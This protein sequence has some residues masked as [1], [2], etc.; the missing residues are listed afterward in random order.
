MHIDD[1]AIY[2]QTSLLMVKY[3]TMLDM[4]ASTQSHFTPGSSSITTSNRL[5][6][7]EAGSFYTRKEMPKG[8]K[9]KRRRIK[10]M[11]ITG[12]TQSLE[13][14]NGVAAYGGGKAKGNNSPSC[15]NCGGKTGHYAIYCRLLPR[16]ER[17]FQVVGKKRKTIATSRVSVT[18]NSGTIVTVLRSSM[19]TIGRTDTR[20]TLA[21]CS[22]YTANAGAAPLAMA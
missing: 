3:C 6:P 10:N 11:E 12:K 1:M 9:G 19:A 2:Q 22:S 7:M 21:S 8:R 13:H 15:Y 4:S 16:F 5:A 20:A 17:E 18:T 14:G